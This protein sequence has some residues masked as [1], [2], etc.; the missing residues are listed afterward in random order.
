MFIVGHRGGAQAIHPENT[1]T[2]LKEGMRCADFVEIDIRL[3]KDGIPVVMHDATL[4]R[5][6][7]G[8]GLVSEKTLREIQQFDAGG[9]PSHP[10]TAG[11]V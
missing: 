6:T 4:D 10:D 2:A 8:S 1:V 9:W 7:D 5:T 3:T 11:C